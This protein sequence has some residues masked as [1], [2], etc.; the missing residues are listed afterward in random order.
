MKTSTDS[1]ASAVPSGGRFLPGSLRAAYRWLRRGLWPVAVCALSVLPAAAAPILTP[2][3]TT[4]GGIVRGGNFVTGLPG[5][6]FDQNNWPSGQEPTE[7]VDGIIGP[8]SKYLNFNITNTALI[9]SGSTQRVADRMELWVAEDAVERDPASYTLY[10]TNSAIP[11]LNPGNSISLVL[12]QLST[13]TLALPDTRDTTQDA[14]GFSQIIPVPNTNAWSSYLLVFPTVKN[15]PSAAN[16]MQISEVQLYDSEIIGV[17]QFDY[18]DGPIADKNGGTFWNW[19]N[20]N[21]AGRTTT[22]PS[23]WDAATAAPA[24]ASGRLVTQNSAAQREYNGPGEGLPI[25]TDEGLGAISAFNNGALSFRHKTVYYRV[26]VTT[27][28]TLTPDNAITLT[29]SDFG[30]DS[31]VFGKLPGG[32]NF[33]IRDLRNGSAT[34]T[35]TTAVAANTTYTLV[36]KLDFGN[37]TTGTASLFLVLESD[38]NAAEPAVPLVTRSFNSTFW[39]SRLKLASTGTAAV[40]WDDLVIATSWDSLGTVVTTLADEDD[41]TLGGGAGVSL[42]EAV[43]YSPTGSIITFA[44]GLSGGTI[45]LN[46]TDGDM[47]IPGAVTIDATALPGGLTVSGNGTHRHFFVDSGKSLTLRGLTLTGGNGTGPV[48]NNNGGAIFSFG[49]LTLTHCTLSGNAASSLGGAIRNTSTLTLTHCTLSGNAASFGGAISSNGPATLTHCTLSGNAASQSGGA[50]DNVSPLTLNNSIVAGNSLTGAGSGADIY[51]A[52]DLVTRVGTNLVQS[53]VNDVGSGGRESGPA[54]INADPKLS[55]LG[56]FGGP[57]QTMHPLIGSPAIDAAGS[58]N[59]GGTD[60]R[61][62]PRFVD[63]DNLGGSQLDIGAVEAGPA[64]LVTQ[65]ND[66]GNGGNLRTRIANA[67]IFSEP[68]VRVVFDPSVFPASTITLTNNQLI[69][70]AGK[71]LFIDA[72]NIPGGVTIS[73]GG[74]SRVFN[75]PATA[76]VAMHSLKIVSG[77]TTGNGNG[78][79]GG[80]LNAGTCTVMSSTLSGNSAFAG[81]GIANYGT[82]T[83]L[84]STLSGNSGNFNGGGIFNISNGFNGTCSVLSS[85]LSGNSAS[86]RGGGISIIGTLHSSHSI[87]AGN[88]APTGPNISGTLAT[89]MQNLI[90]ATPLLAPLADYGG[91][92]QTMP[93]LP[94]SPAVDVAAATTAQTDQRGFPRSRDGDGDGT[95]LPDLGAV[96]ASHIIVTVPGDSGPGS[97]RA[98]LTEAATQPGPDTVY[99]APSATP[100]ATPYLTLAS[101]ILITDPAGVTLDATDRPTGLVI[102]AGTGTNRHF[103]IASGTTAAFN[104]LRLYG[105]NGDGG[106]GATALNGGAIHNS[107]TLALRECTISD[108][109]TTN[110]GGAIFN[111]N[112]GVLTIERSTLHG[113][114]AANGSGAIL[115]FSS[116]LLTL[117]SCTIANNTAGFQAGAVNS[118]ASGPVSITHCTITGNAVTKPGGG[119]VGGVRGVPTGFVTVRDSIISGNTDAN[120]PSTPNIN[121]D[122]IS[123][124]NNVIGGDAKLAAL[125]HYGGPTWTMPPMPGSA[126]IDTATTS[127]A[128]TDQRN[129]A[130]P[131][132]GDNTGGTV[133]DIGAVEAPPF[134]TVDTE[135]DEN[136]TPAGP[137]LSLREAIRDAPPGATIL[138][139]PSIFNGE[140]RDTIT[141]RQEFGEI[142]FTK[143]LILNASANTGGVTIDGGPGT[144]RIFYL[145][146]GT[147]AYLNRLTLTGGGGSG[148]QGGAIRC[149]EATLAL[150]DCALTGNTVSDLGGAIVNFQCTLTLDRC[151]LSGNSGSVGGAIY[152]ITADLT[153]PAISS[154]TLTNCTIT[155]NT[156][157]SGTGGIHNDNG[158]ATLLHCT[159]TGNTA[160][161]GNVSGVFSFGDAAT[162]T[163]VQNCLIAG[164]ANASDVSSGTVSS[165]LSLGGNLIGSGNAAPAFNQ[166]RDVTG[167]T[168]ASLRLAPL[169]D[170]GGPTHTIALRPGSPARDNATPSPITTDQRGFGIVIG[171]KDSGAY[172]AGNLA[173]LATTLAETLPNTG[174]AS[175]VTPE[176]DFDGDGASNQLEWVAGTVL[177]N[178]TS[179]FRPIFVQ[180]GGNFIISFPTV[181][182]K[183]YLL[184][185]SDDVSGTWINNGNATITGDGSVK[186]FLAPAPIIGVPRRFYRVQVS[187]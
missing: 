77:N 80:I 102:D 78:D 40:T 89:D 111:G 156:G 50:I 114:F 5:T 127:T 110:V 56:Y 94:G 1:H 88:T 142:A 146:A 30:T 57:V 101:E 70:P 53:L 124:G 84:S 150:A 106:G 13:G 69:P 135:V 141:L 35:S 93:P 145:P 61:G 179:F 24:V 183:T 10:G 25:S 153:G 186:Q 185:R 174:P 126:A 155:N 43:K 134:L 8:G 63:G 168:A 46:H 99:F 170:Y 44:P 83:V 90:N 62:F 154:T 26:T 117:T 103:R 21:P 108:C 152:A 182:G 7:A 58:T 97:L 75:I 29:S 71:A 85:T 167:H 79:G 107:G 92:T 65:A 115:H 52:V 176:G 159:I 95:A 143:G 64:L 120:L 162:R 161:A 2:S 12:T 74:F 178:A 33:A 19:R 66:F 22:G 158:R 37:G 130:R 55:P 96:E 175:G 109:T 116:G 105:G 15:Q 9:F 49:T 172:E 169:A 131:L 6:T 76:T 128:P 129:V 133:R 48:S 14:T 184:Q 16:S 138:F 147:G 132:N 41:L 86:N 187:N 122:F 32:S 112:P 157:T 36:A 18:P 160:P 31:V 39:S 45:T 118:I 125:G 28:A 163:T 173:N 11:T 54:A 144:N 137:Q 91:P 98:A 165:F 72:S 68:G 23:D 166:L 164:N 82:C 27:G 59:P 181:T 119:G 140:P 123:S 148:L 177:I 171:T 104:R 47:E 51:N 67:G 3:T 139:H 100:A 42:R 81:G 87:I 136:D 34:T 180:S 17:D 151:L 149:Q 73:G 4:Y 113:N 38:L 20:Q 60:A 121:A